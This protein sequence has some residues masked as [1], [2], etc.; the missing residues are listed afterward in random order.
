MQREGLSGTFELQS[1]FARRVKAILDRHGKVLV[2]WNELSHGGGIDPENTLLMAWER[3]EVGIELARMGYD[4]VM[5]PGQAYYMDMVQGPDW[6]E[7]GAGWAGPVPPAQ[8]YGYEAAGDFPEDLAQHMRG[9]QSCIWCEHF[10][11]VDWFNDM[12]F[13]RLSAVAEAAWTQK[14]DK[15]WL[16]FAAQVRLHPKL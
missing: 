10:T 4:V 5:T 2:G 7:N 8:T 15:D 11:T 12:V 9:I 1:W 16:R 14:A 3:P 13:P 6:L